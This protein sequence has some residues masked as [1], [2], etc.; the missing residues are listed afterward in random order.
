VILAQ[1]SPNLKHLFLNLHGVNC[2]RNEASPVGATADCY[3]DWIERAV[4]EKKLSLAP[5]PLAV[6]AEGRTGEGVQR[7]E[8]P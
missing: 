3:R 1:V 7:T 2:P 8:Q 4:I 6:G 5:Y